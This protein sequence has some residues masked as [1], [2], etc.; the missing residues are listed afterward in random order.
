MRLFRGKVV[1]E[2]IQDKAFFAKLSRCAFNVCC[3]LHGSC[4]FP[5]WHPAAINRWQF[6][7][8]WVCN[9]GTASINTVSSADSSL[10]KNLLHDH[11]KRSATESDNLA[12]L[13]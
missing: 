7:N 8:S 13:R 3:V 1:I 4:K 5:S 9:R 11:F 2:G 10:V 12:G 6:H